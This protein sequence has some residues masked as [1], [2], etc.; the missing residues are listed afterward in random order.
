MGD[1]IC[2]WASGGAILPTFLATFSGLEALSSTAISCQHACISHHALNQWYQ[3][4]FEYLEETGNL[5]LLDKPLR[6]FNADETGFP[7]APW[8]AKVLAGKGDPSV[9]QQGSSDKSQITVLMMSNAVALYIP[10]LVSILDVTFARHSLKTYS[11][12]PTAIFGHSTNGWMD[13]ELFKKWLEESFIPKIEKACIPKLVLLVINGA[14]C[15]ISLPISELCDDNNII[16]YTLLL[17]VT[18]LIQPLDLSLVGSIKTNYQEC[19]CKWLQNNP[20]GIYD[21]NAFIEVFAKV[22]NKAA[23]VE[24]AVSGFHHAG[25][26]PWDPTKVDD[27]KTRT[28]RDIQERRADARC[29]CESE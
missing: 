25:I 13:A 8:P 4:L 1:E 3:E 18:H 23:T 29:K 17:N 11:H 28:C 26:F 27:K 20:G 21:K 19:I 15:H 6:I 2:P 10:P 12:F 9:Y 16:L 7:M 14:K 5:S 22:H 24:N